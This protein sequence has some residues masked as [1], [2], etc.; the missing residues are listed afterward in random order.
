MKRTAALLII[1][2][3]VILMP[4]R[5]FAQRPDSIQENQIVSAV[6]KYHDGNY[7]VAR[8]ILNDILQ[9]DINNDAAWYYS[10]LISLA[11]FRLDSAVSISFSAKLINAE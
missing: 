7:D 4:Q 2:L 9:K 6:Q 3:M 11:D 1:F 10:A 5:M 8:D